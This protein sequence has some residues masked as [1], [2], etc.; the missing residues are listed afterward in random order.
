MG[1]IDDITT[2]RI[3]IFFISFACPKR[4]EAKKMAP[5]IP[6][7]AVFSALHLLNPPRKAAAVDFVELAIQIARFTPFSV[8][9]THDS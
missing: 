5:K 8:S 7:S 2:T 4:N 6:T 9:P 3:L 1:L